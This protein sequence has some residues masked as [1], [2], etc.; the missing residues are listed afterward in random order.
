MKLFQSVC[1][2]SAI[3]GIRPN[4]LHQKYPFNAK[5]MKIS[6]CYWLIIIL[7]CLHL[8]KN[9]HSFADYSDSIHWISFV[10]IL[11]V[12]HTIL[13][14]NVVKMFQIFDSCEKIIDKSKYIHFNESAKKKILC[15]ITF[16]LKITSGMKNSASSTFYENIDERIEKWSEIIYITLMKVIPLILSV[17]KILYNIYVYFVIGLDENDTLE[18]PLPM[19]LVR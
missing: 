18:L 17:P 1:S 4:Q 8:S 5:A 9:A 13:V 12:C 10:F 15:Q 3:L 19:W 11:T 16:S 14:F 7:L 6:L 2:D